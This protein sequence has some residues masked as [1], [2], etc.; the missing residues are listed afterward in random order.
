MTTLI[1]IDRKSI[2]KNPNAWRDSVHIPM[3]WNTSFETNLT[4]FELPAWL[5]ENITLVSVEPPCTKGWLDVV[6]DR[7]IEFAQSSI[8]KGHKFNIE[9]KRGIQTIYSLTPEPEYNYKY[10][11]TKVKCSCCKS[12][13]LHSEIE[14]DEFEDTLVKICPKCGDVDTFDYKYEE[15]EEIMK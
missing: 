7:L 3:A 2:K 1:K 5:R 13:I 15:I 8:K 12:M 11:N 6:D 9:C 4:P 10:K 14:E